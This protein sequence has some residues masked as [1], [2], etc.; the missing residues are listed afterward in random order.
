MRQRAR[1]VLLALVATSTF[2]GCALTGDEE[3]SSESAVSEKFRTIWA[4]LKEANGD[5]WAKIGTKLLSDKMQDGIS[6]NRVDFDWDVRAAGKQGKASSL[7]GLTV[8][9]LDA[10][11]SGL[12]QKFGEGDLPAQVNKIRRDRVQDGSYYLDANTKV[13]LDGSFGWGS[14]GPNATDF[15]TM[16]WFGFDAK[17]SLDSR[18]VV[19]APSDSVKEQGKAWLQSLMKERDY[20]LH[21]SADKVLE[22]KPGEMWGLRGQGTL[23]AHVGVGIPIV[24]GQPV[25][26]ILSAGA[27]AAMQ[28]MLDVQ[29]VRLDDK[30]VVVDLGIEEGKISGWSVGLGTSYGMPGSC[31]DSAAGQD[32][33]ACLPQVNDIDLSDS[34]P[35]LTKKLVNSYLGTNITVGGK[36]GDSRLSVLRLKFDFGAKGGNSEE[37]KRAFARAI[38]L[39]AREAQT[40][41]Y[42]QIDNPKR[43]VTV[44]ADLFRSMSSGVRYTNWNAFGMRVYEKTDSTYT[45]AMALRTPTETQLVSYDVRN[46]RSGWFE[47]RHGFDRMG[48]ASIGTK[49]AEANL[50]F[51][52]AT[53]D[54]R[55][56]ARGLITNNADAALAA[57]AGRKA[58]DALDPFG[59]PLEGRIRFCGAGNECAFKELGGNDLPSATT[60]FA[61]AVQGQIGKLGFGADDYGK[62][63]AEA[64][65]I[66]L[67]AQGL[68]FGQDVNDGPGVDFTYGT[69]FDN[70]GLATLMNPGRVDDFK[71]RAFDYLA[72]TTSIE[73]EFIGEVKSSSPAKFTKEQLIARLKMRDV[74]APATGVPEILQDPK[75]PTYGKLVEALAAIYKTSAEE[76]S[77]LASTETSAQE[78]MKSYEGRY[79]PV[80]VGVSLKALKSADAALEK[81]QE[82]AES[83]AFG[84]VAHKRAIAA[85]GLFD[86]LYKEASGSLKMQT[87]LWSEH[88]VGYTLASLVPTNQ[89]ETTLDFR[90]SGDVTARFKAAGLDAWSP[91]V[92]EA[93]KSKEDVLLAYAKSGCDE[94]GQRLPKVAGK[95]SKISLGP[96]DLEAVATNSEKKK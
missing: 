42:Q 23:G 91:C 22:M 65:R 36:K 74:N 21:K 48:F 56:D 72:T 40:L 31:R 55:L 5:D 69:R 2:S 76:Y 25:S 46:R 66:R 16:V 34:V 94:S 61:G 45:G 26:V 50:V 10:L 24:I 11:S 85:T 75:Y 43:P 19:H 7:P 8:Y 77:A 63:S 9:D 20:F 64:A 44:E 90:V 73:R 32:K 35:K 27:S 93:G 92:P 88:L 52:L 81:N 62:I 78:A 14:D 86:K 4:D 1:S 60:A 68:S 37:V 96:L 54:K 17:A 71:A 29:V 49:G 38:R 95:V 87:H 57:L 59:N 84:S 15:K 39:D 47:T 30:Q 89:R 67:V 12:L 41:Y 51:N 28:G 79:V 83:V 3:E 82:T 58:S 6:R 18:V 80:F 33:S 13:T 53:S 70:A